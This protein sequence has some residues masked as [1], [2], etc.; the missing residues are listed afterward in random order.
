MKLESRVVDLKQL[1]SMSDQPLWIPIYQRH[2]AWNV[3]ECEQLWVDITDL[4]R[5]T[6][7]MGTIVLSARTDGQWEI[8]DGQQRLSTL[9]MLLAAIRDEFMAR[10]PDSFRR[11]DGLI[12]FSDTAEPDRL[13]GRVVLSHANNDAFVHHVIA[14]P[15]DPRRRDAG[16]V[17]DAQ[18]EGEDLNWRLVR[19]ADLLRALVRKDIAPLAE[20]D[21]TGA[22]STKQKASLDALERRVLHGLKFVVVQVLDADED[23]SFYETINNRGMQLSAADLIKSQLLSRIVKVGDTDVARDVELQWSAAIASLRGADADMFL[24]CYLLLRR[25]VVPSNRIFRTFMDFARE[26]E[27]LELVRDVAVQADL[28]AS[29]VSPQNL[30]HEA[31]REVLVGVAR[32]NEPSCYLTLLPALQ[33]FGRDL[34]GFTRFARLVQSMSFRWAVAMSQ[35]DHEAHHRRH[36]A[37]DRSR[38]QGISAEESAGSDT[39]PRD[40]ETI[41]SGAG[42]ILHSEGRDGID[43]ASDYLLHSLP[44]RM[45][46]IEAATTALVDFDC[47]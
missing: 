1:L 5:P 3:E 44:N 29:L 43:A 41:L 11:L 36:H 17:L 31:M 15:T 34:D 26:R 46:F 23:F 7:F 37:R 4:S 18:H 42:R 27:I 28:Y 21:A 9:I 6:R 22:G 19:N 8:V 12:R 20:V 13:L 25:E 10:D 47:C 33:A 45:Q 24:R 16:L 2:Y 38:G 39:I 35:A 32:L 30:D 14:S 40:L